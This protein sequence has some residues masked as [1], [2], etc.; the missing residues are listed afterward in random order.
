MILPIKPF[1]GQHCETTATGTLLRQLDIDLSEPLLFGLGEGLGFIF[2]NMKSMTF[3]F[4]GGRI[5]TD[6]LTQNIAENLKLELTVRETAS[7]QKAWH[8]VKECLDSG[9]VVGLK[10]DCFHLQYFSRSFHFAGH[11]AAIYGYDDENAYL[12]DT[13]QQGGRVK[14][15]LKSL[16][17]ARAE[18]GPMSSR[19]LYYTLQKTDHKLDMKTAITAAI[20]NNAA[21]YLNP[22]ITNIGYKGILKTSTEIVKW[23]KTSKD[24][25]NEFKTSAMMMEKAGTGGALFRNLYRDFLKES[26]NLLKI[27]K[28]NTGYESFSEIA[29]LWTSISQLFDKVS[30]T[31]D[32][33]YILKASA[34]LKIIADKEK[35]TMELLLTV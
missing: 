34:I 2:W 26:Y 11:Y 3:P 24:I 10:M 13:R 12:V 4:I 21:D 17:L 28:L 18:K 9:K 23:F 5:K 31:A 33:S 29:E 30:E 6:L 32:L 16:E 14:T 27:E 22:P 19:N 20:R 35:K 25:Q 15:S 8:K 7:V 1:D